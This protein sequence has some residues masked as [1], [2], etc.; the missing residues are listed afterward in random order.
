MTKLFFKSAFTE[1][2][3]FKSQNV[4]SLDESCPP[5]IKT[6]RCLHKGAVKTNKSI[7]KPFA[8]KKR[9]LENSYVYL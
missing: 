3:F 9:G 1:I 2:Y 7:A 8:S 4:K 5:N 6:N